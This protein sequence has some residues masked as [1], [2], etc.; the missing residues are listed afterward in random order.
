[1]VVIVGM[2]ARESLDGRL[3]DAIIRLAPPRFRFEP[4]PIGNVPLYSRGQ[5]AEPVPGRRTPQEP[6]IRARGL[7]S[8]AI[9]AAVKSMS[10]LVVQA[11]T[12]AEFSAARA[13]FSEY[14]ST[15][16]V[17][18]AFQGFASELNALQ[19]MYGAP[20][21]CLLLARGHGATVGCIAVRR[22]SSEDCEMKRLYVRPAAR[23]GGIGRR[24]I[25]AAI[26]R[27]QSM[28]YKRMLLD[29]LP[30]MSAARTLYAA[31]GFRETGPY[32][33]NPIPGTTFMA[34]D[35]SESGR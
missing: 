28:G 17:D 8:L 27:A 11:K 23:G 31:L 13:L 21:G 19:T 3:A 30:D 4:L 24:L 25:M 33:H 35:L 2:L 29:T 9:D 20:G 26:E 15:L 22:L 16:E 10:S 12:D 34:L 1:M 18:L 14:A 32:C 6:A 5:E 7:H